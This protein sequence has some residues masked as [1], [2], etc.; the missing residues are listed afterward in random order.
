MNLV[1]E[2]VAAALPWIIRPRIAA[3]F[4]GI[5][6]GQAQLLT[7]A[8]HHQ[9]KCLLRPCPVR[10]V[11]DGITQHDSVRCFSQGELDIIAGILKHHRLPPGGFRGDTAVFAGRT[12][13]LAVRNCIL[14]LIADI[15][16]SCPAIG[17]RHTFLDRE[18]LNGY[19]TPVGIAAAERNR[20]NTS[21]QH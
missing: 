6:G 15:R 3:V 8:V 1:K 9:R 14:C 10:T 7:L 2:A 17:F 13:K 19:L 12:Y 16:H 18:T 11:R 20:I 21:S 4:P 5:F